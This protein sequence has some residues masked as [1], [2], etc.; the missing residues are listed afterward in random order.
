[1][2]DELE[3]IPRLM[4]AFI[5]G[6]ALG[7]ERERRGKPAGLRT[8][9]LVAVSS[10]M[11]MALSELIRGDLPDE[12]G[13]PVRMAQGVLTGIGFIGAGTILRREDTVIG[14]TTAGTIWMAAALGLTAGAGFYVLAL[15]GTALAVIAVN[16]LGR[17]DRWLD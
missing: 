17:L 1:M 5:L 8:H 6:A 2:T 16:L 14:L 11:L 15:C 12:I 7:Y 9:V 3:M 4:A 10:A 13:D